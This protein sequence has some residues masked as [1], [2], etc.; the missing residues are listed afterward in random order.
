MTYSEPDMYSS[1]PGHRGVDTSIEAADAIASVTARLQR[2]VLAWIRAKGADGAT[3]VEIADGIKV[4]RASAQPRTS[5]LRQLG[6]I[7]DSG[8][9]RHNPN[10][11]RAIV[12]VAIGG[13]A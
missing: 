1:T 4:D 12:W 10:G 6:L 13:A 2:A 3:T 7:D 11:K 9:R 5:E 8:R